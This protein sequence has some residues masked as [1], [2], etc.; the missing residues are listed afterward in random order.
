[1]CVWRCCPVGRPTS[2]NRD[3][4]LGICV[5][6]PKPLD[7][8]LISQFLAHIQ[9]LHYSITRGSKA[10]PQHYI[11]CFAAPDTGGLEHPQGCGSSSRTTT[12]NTHQKHPGIVQEETLDCSGVS[13][14]ESRSESH[15]NTMVR[16][17]NSSWWRTPLKRWRM[18][19]V[20]VEE[21]VK[22]L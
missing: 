15:Q 13:R 22:L 2:F 11:N 8:L 21:W 17:E 9:G 3:T 7:N 18:R 6:Y 4:V 5:E 10:T 20:V 14:D 1:M 12:S 19:A 16:A